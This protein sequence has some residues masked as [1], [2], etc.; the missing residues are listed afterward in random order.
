VSE[1][2]CVCVCVCLFLCFFVCVSGATFQSAPQEMPPPAEP[3]EPAPKKQGGGFL[4]AIGLGGGGEATRRTWVSIDLVLFGRG[5]ARGGAGRKGV[6]VC[7]CVCVEE[8]GGE[9]ER[10]RGERGALRE[11]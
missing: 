10:E 4:A 1:C 2:A 5:G 3:A 7:V 11:S 9:R 6:C 8:G